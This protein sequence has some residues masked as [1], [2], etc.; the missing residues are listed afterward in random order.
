MHTSI[1]QAWFLG[2]GAMIGSGALATGLGWLAQATIAW[3]G[4]AG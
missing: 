3:A 2:L 1:A 4:L